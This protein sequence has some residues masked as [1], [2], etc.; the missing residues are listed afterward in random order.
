M[1]LVLGVFFSQIVCWPLPGSC[2][3]NQGVMSCVTVRG[4]I[5]QFGSGC[6][7]T[8]GPS[9]AKPIWREQKVGLY[10]SFASN[11]HQQFHLSLTSLLFF[12]GVMFAL[13]FQETDCSDF[14]GE[15]K[16]TK[17]W[18]ESFHKSLGTLKCVGQPSGL[19]L[20]ALSPCYHGKFTVIT[21]F[22]KIMKLLPDYFACR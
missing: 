7:L 9:V 10:R 16:T 4:I 18:S 14:Q 21:L 1:D 12:S 19:C 20:I 5:L 6:A 2:S 22:F 17:V 8:N 15:I 13:C 3:I 11:I